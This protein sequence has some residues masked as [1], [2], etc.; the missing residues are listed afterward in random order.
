MNYKFLEPYKYFKGLVNKY[1]GMLHVADYT[2][3]NNSMNVH[4]NVTDHLYSQKPVL[5]KK[6]I[7]VKN[8]IRCE[9]DSKIESLNSD[10]SVS[11]QELTDLID[12]HLAD[13]AMYI[14][15]VNFLI[16]LIN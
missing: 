5:V 12:M 6:G 15:T 2:G 8:N 9:I 14:D 11:S 10:P 3:D 16:D 4:N 13:K 7:L 1:M